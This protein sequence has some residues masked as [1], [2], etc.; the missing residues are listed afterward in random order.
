MIYS[1]E[2][3]LD[4]LAAQLQS[5]EATLR[6][7]AA[8]NQAIVE[9]DPLGIDEV[10][11]QLPGLNE[12]HNIEGIRQ[13]LEHA[14]ARA[15]GLSRSDFIS[16]NAAIRD[17][18]MLAASLIRFEVESADCVSS[19]SE[20][21]LALSSNVAT[22]IP[23]DSFIDYTSRNP[24]NERVRT[25]T[26]LPQERLFIES[27]RQGMFSLDS[28][29]AHLLIACTYP[30]SHQEFAVHLHS[31]TISFQAMIDSIVQ[32]KRGITPEVF[33]HYIRPFFEPFRVGDRA[34][35]A[36][37]GAEMPILN[38][39]QIIWGADCTDELYTTYFQANIIRLPAIYQRISQTFAGQKSLITALKDR[40]ASTIPL[41]HEERHS[42]QELHLLLT[43]MYTFRMPHYKVAEENV[44]LRQQEYGADYEAKGSGGFGLPETKYVLD[45][46]IKCRQ[47][48]SQV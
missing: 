30:I 7:E 9:A 16:C 37:S 10:F 3:W 41:S 26:S 27:L 44:I 46:T 2:P 36:P 38:I 47:I 25:F 24:S 5:L 32:V 19:F 8:I 20:T 43:K 22:Q 28:C 40:L 33:T 17:L 48:T 21:L 29:L 13:A 23:R 35:S 42:I 4:G 12:Q 31:A 34:F 14:V 18:S 6:S 11:L 39:D 45:Q 15:Q 1:N